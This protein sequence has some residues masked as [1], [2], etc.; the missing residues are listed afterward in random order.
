MILSFSARQSLRKPFQVIS[1]PLLAKLYRNA[2]SLPQ[3]RLQRFITA[4]VSRKLHRLFLSLHFTGRGRFKYQGSRTQTEIFFRSANTQFH[5]LYL[6]Q[7]SYFE[8]ETLALLDILIQPND[9]FYDIG[10]NWGHVSLHAASLPGF[11]GEIHAFEP[12]P[13]TFPDLVKTVKQAGLEA[14]V[15]CHHYA[16]SDTNEP[17]YM[18]LPD[19]IHSGNATLSM[20]TKG[21]RTERKKLDDLHISPPNILKVDAEGHEPNVFGGGKQMLA[22]HTPYIIFENFRKPQ[23]PLS[24]LHP[25]FIL[26]ELDYVFFLPLFYTLYEGIPVHQGSQDHLPDTAPEAL[27][28]LFLFQAEERF[29]LDEQINIF[30]C[31]KN[32]LEE[33][34]Q[35]FKNAHPS[36]DL[37]SV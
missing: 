16:L 25:L 21:V 12:M 23:E 3:N 35:L 8:A 17:G 36:S 20:D 37:Q 26:Q 1:L 30:A 24:T 29:F 9:V 15:S 13:A 7:F 32:R 33:L 4:P 27:L 18:T 5:S 14:T 28:G 34:K 22:E 19:G 6:P 31:H 11:T 10:S 2:Y